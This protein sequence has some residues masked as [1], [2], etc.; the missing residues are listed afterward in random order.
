MRFIVS[1][2]ISA[3]SFHA[4][5]SGGEEEAPDNKAIQHI[6]VIYLEN[7]G[8]D[9]LYGLFPGANG[10]QQAANAASQTD[11]NG[12]SY[13][14]LP[15]VM[16]AEHKPAEVDER[17]P[18]GLPNK[19]FPID[20]YVPANQ[21]IGDLVHRFYQNQAQINGGLND[22]FAAV[23][24]AGGLVMGYYDGHN[25]P[26]WKYA[27]KYTLADNFFQGAFGGSFLNHFWL[28][29]ACTPRYEQAPEEVTIKLDTTGNLLK[30]GGVTPDGY[31]VNTLQPSSPPIKPGIAPAKQLPPQTMATLGDRLSDKNISWAWYSGGWNDAIAGKATKN[32]QY[33][34]QPYVY[35]K[36]YAEGSADRA[37]HLKDETDFIRALDTGTLPAVSFYK[38]VGDLNEHPGYA[39]LL[40][41]EQHIA[42]LLARIETSPQWKNTA[43]IV[44]YDE[45]GGFWDHVAPPKKDRWGPGTRVPTLVISPYAKR[46]FVDHTEYDTTSILKLIEVR[47]GL[48]ALTER[49]ANT[50]DLSNAFEF[51][52]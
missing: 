29:C 41:G 32:F 16:N 14:T 17:F 2:I 40:A 49:D 22:R 25:L 26:L 38:P 5:A 34:H 42:D 20:Q 50:H 4:I 10:L 15:L 12:K 30:D 24:D 35:F 37:V 11:L 46:G 6:V 44:T 19:P 8:F 21:K 31:A 43:V 51:N 7:H 48:K 52:R 18:K 39:E 33:H 9:N 27:Q 28:A 3:L 47:F 45:N 13:T 1:L 36:R 23:S